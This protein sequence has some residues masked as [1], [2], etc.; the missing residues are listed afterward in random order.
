MAVEP[1][2]G[3][4]LLVFFFPELCECD[5]VA[6][7][8]PVCTPV[9]PA[10]AFWFTGA[11]PPLEGADPWTG[12]ADGKTT[13]APDVAG[14]AVTM[15]GISAARSVRPVPANAKDTISTLSVIAAPIAIF[16]ARPMRSPAPSGIHV[17]IIIPTA[18]IRLYLVATG[19]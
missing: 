10:P 6:L 8:V 3:F 16:I 19:C 14:R 1:P 7:E 5:D 17:A 9:F 15:T 18:G 13:D 12:M 11:G 4:F 2:C